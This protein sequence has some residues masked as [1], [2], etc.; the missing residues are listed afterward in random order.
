MTTRQILVTAPKSTLTYLVRAIRDVGVIDLRVLE[1]T[2]PPGDPVLL[3]LADDDDRQ[4]LLD[5][6]Q[7]IEEPNGGTL[8]DNS[9][10]VYGAGLGDGNEHDA[11]DLP[12]LVAAAAEEPS[13]PG[14]S[15][16]TRSRP[17]SPASPSRCSSL[18]AC[19]STRSG[20]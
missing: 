15:S 14:G 7:A 18:W 16:S 12:T 6:M 5:R 13:R 9:L 10:I 8:L 20:R 17:T 19:R 2:D 3:I 1:A 11:S 4:T